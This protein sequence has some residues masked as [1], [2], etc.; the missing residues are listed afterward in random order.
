MSSTGNGIVAI[1]YLPGPALRRVV[2]SVAGAG[3]GDSEPLL[4]GCCHAETW[5]LVKVDTRCTVSSTVLLAACTE[6]SAGA[7]L[8]HPSVEGHIPFSLS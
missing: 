2:H 3:I 1:L 5:S 8:K 7:P 6:D 4:D